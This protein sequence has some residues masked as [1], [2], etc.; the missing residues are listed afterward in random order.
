MRFPTYPNFSIT[1]LVRKQVQ[2]F[3]TIWATK[4]YK[5]NN[6]VIKSRYSY[7]KL[8]NNSN[9]NVIRIFYELMHMYVDIATSS[10]TEIA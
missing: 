7:K 8:T 3:L 9:D 5:P 2:R 1:A 10:K 4:I 6:K